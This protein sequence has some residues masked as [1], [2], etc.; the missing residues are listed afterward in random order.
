MNNRHDAS[1]SVSA[2][3]VATLK[4]RCSALVI[5]V[6]TSALRADLEYAASVL[7]RAHRGELLLASESGQVAFQTLEEFV[8]RCVARRGDVAEVHCKFESA[9]PADRYMVKVELVARI[10]DAIS[11]LRA[12]ELERRRDVSPN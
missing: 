4:P 3:D 2:S 8:E 7:S 1:F 10:R 5:D 9:G 6:D 11:T 12:I